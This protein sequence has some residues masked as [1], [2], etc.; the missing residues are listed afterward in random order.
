[1]ATF[2]PVVGGTS[3]GSTPRCQVETDIQIPGNIV[4]RYLGWF[5]GPLGILM[6]P[7]VVR[8]LPILIDV[9]TYCDL[10]RDP[11]NDP[12]GSKAVEGMTLEPC[13]FLRI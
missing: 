10:L 2:V 1:M 7:L 3:N 5:I 13:L 11:K 6:S 8:I 12:T 4:V 9:L